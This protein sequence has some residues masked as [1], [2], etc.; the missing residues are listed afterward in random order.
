MDC[1][2]LIALRSCD[3]AV[4]TPLDFALTEK[5]D[6]AQLAFAV[7][8]GFVIYTH[9]IADF[10]RLHTQWVGAG[11]EHAGIIL[12]AQQRFIVGEQFRRILNIR[13]SVSSERMKNRIEFLSNWG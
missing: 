6:E 13:A 5:S 8:R 3:V 2:L 10:C 1:D 11:R 7:K 9:N 12:A 4:F